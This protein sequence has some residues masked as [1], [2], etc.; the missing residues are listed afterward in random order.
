LCFSVLS[1]VNLLFLPQRARRGTE[2]FVLCV[3]LCYP[4]W[5]YCFTTEG[6]ER[7]GGFFLCV[8]L[9]SPWWV[10]LLPF[11]QY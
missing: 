4:W 9:C 6:M 10:I 7:H 8:S 11:P 2:V 1:V 3:S 5:I